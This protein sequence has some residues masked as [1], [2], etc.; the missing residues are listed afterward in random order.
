MSYELEEKK[1]NYDEEMRPKLFFGVF[2]LKGTE[3]K[4]DRWDFGKNYAYIF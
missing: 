1:L 2:R 4:K 3:E